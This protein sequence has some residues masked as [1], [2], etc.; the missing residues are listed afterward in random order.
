[1]GLLGLL[2]LVPVGYALMYGAAG[3]PALGARG[4]GYATVI[5][6]AA[7]AGGFAVWLRYS[8]RYRGI[9]WRSGSRRLDRAAI[10]GLL[11]I[12][13]P[14]A[15]SLVLEIALFSAAGLVIGRFGEVAE[16]GHQV[17][18]SVASLTFMMP[19]GVSIATT[20]RV[21]NAV[22]RGDAAGVRRAGACGM[23]L[24]LLL[25]GCSG[26]AM[27]L[28]PE[29]IARLY[30][31]QPEVIRAAVTFLQIAGVF[32]LSDGLQVA[33]IGALRGL[34]DT[35]V[36]MLIT[37]FSYW[38]IGFPVALLLTF[39]LGYGPTGMWYGLIAGLTVAAALLS[40]RFSHLSA[41]L[42]QAWPR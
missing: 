21:G 3:L 6:T 1:M 41:R 5:A 20:V 31:T 29:P 17:A 18:L 10:A 8:G 25:Q 26:A 34:K 37:A 23:A 40:A 39:P 19:L 4:A 7:Q 16:S 33:G 13:V 27:L 35:R 11:R 12:G 22:G 36:P 2:V 14:M 38:G 42:T 28:A 32:Q 9:G 24:A 15:V 30:T